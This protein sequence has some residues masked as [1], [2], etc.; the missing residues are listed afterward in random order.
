MPFFIN[1]GVKMKKEKYVYK[2]EP[3]PRAI[4]IDNIMKIVHNKEEED[5]LLNKEE[6]NEPELKNNSKRSNKKINDANRD[7]GSGRKSD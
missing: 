7:I 5:K 1:K 3:Y 6:K 2:Y 4:Y